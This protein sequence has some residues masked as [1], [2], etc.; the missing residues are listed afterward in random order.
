MGALQKLSTVPRDRLTVVE[1][2]RSKLAAA[3]RRLLLFVDK[4][5]DSYAKQKRKQQQQ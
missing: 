2:D 3:V 1:A 5:C 4:F